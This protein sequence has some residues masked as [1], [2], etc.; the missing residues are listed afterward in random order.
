MKTECC[1]NCNHF[2]CPKYCILMD[3]IVEP[4]DSCGMCDT[5]DR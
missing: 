3:E 4:N 2:H 1:G 5:N